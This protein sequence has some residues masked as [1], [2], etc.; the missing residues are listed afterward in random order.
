MDDFD[1]GWSLMPVTKDQAHALAAL[2][3]ACRPYGAPRWDEV[4][5][6]AAI[7]KVR[8]LALPD[9]VLAAVRAADDRTTKTPGVL[10]NTTSP[11]WRERGTDRPTPIEPYRSDRFCHACAKPEDKHSAADHQFLSAARHKAQLGEVDVAATVTA[12]RELVVEAKESKPAPP[13]PAPRERDPRIEAA[14][15]ELANHPA[16]TEQETP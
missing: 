10:A 6:L 15:A 8:H 13:E 9:V 4:G 5:V 11:C 16:R 14:R 3:V 12:L 2:V 7:G 1:R